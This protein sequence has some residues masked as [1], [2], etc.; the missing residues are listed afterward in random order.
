MPNSTEQVEKWDAPMTVTIRRGDL[1]A[2][3][4]A[5]GY[6]NN[7]STL[8]ERAKGTFRAALT[9]EDPAEAGE[10]AT[11]RIRV[12]IDEMHSIMAEL[13]KRDQAWIAT[14]LSY[15]AGG[16]VNLL[17]YPPA[18]TGDPVPLRFEEAVEAACEAG[19]P[20]EVNIRIR[21]NPDDDEALIVEK[22]FRPPV[23]RFNADR[24]LPA[25]HKL[26]ALML[27]E[28]PFADEDDA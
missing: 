18:P 24:E 13:E 14:R 17:A 19:G 21:E 25:T 20:N 27:R 3:A 15:V 4:Q 11:R 7:I 6:A 16:L 2:A 1:D 26:A 28:A 9:K 8:A 10:A 12:A 22:H 5:L 23:D